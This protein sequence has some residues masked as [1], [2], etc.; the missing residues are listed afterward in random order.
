MDNFKDRFEAGRNV[1]LLMDAHF[2]KQ[3]WYVEY[4]GRMKGKPCA[5]SLNDSIILPDLYVFKEDARP[6]AV[7]VKSGASWSWNIF[8]KQFQ[9]GIA[10]RQF[11]DY[12]KYETLTKVPVWIYFLCAG[13]IP[14]HHIEH[15]PKGL[16]CAE[17]A[18]LK[19]QVDNDFQGSSYEGPVDR[20]VYPPT[21]YWNDTR[22]FNVSTYED[23]VG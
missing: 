21:Y 3:G 9:L 5:N 7:E 1:E 16:F 20:I 6:F 13:A 4:K 19:H 10:K 17:V 23:I 11:D 15:S 12:V 2:R 18:T 14:K 22:F 8:Q